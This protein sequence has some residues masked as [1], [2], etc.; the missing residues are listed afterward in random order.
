MPCGGK[1]W[2][3]NGKQHRDNDKPAVT[4]A[5]GG[6][7]W[8]VNNMRHRNNGNPAVIYSNGSQEWWVEYELIRYE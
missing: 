4:Y 3:V 5:D 8:W 7:E 6:K 2:W 1:E